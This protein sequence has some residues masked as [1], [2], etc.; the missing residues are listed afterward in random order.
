MKIGEL[1]ARA[2]SN[3]ET[4]RYY[5]RIGMLPAPAR[6]EGN[7][8]DYGADHVA[9]LSFIRHARALGFELSAIRALLDLAEQPD[10]DCAAVDRI[11]IGHLEVVQA[12]IRQLE[13]LRS[14]LMR[15]LDQCR[16]GQVADCRIIESL[17]DHAGCRS[18]HGPSRAGSF[19]EAQ[20]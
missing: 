3:P 6:T 18:A 12:K 9:R 16:G 7:Y 10:Q 8:R 14:E 20:V 1:A 13:A 4:I 2:G 11:T 15:M 19:G 5:E 17:L